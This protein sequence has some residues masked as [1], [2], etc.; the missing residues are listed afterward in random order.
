M[1]PNVF[2]GT[3]V[4]GQK[5]KG[6]FEIFMGNLNIFSRSSQTLEVF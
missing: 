2:L 5:G 6:E 1:I 3:R 4:T